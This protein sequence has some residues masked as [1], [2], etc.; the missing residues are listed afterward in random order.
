MWPT[1]LRPHGHATWTTTTTQT[2]R[3]SEKLAPHSN[4]SPGFP[5]HVSPPGRQEEFKTQS[6][7]RQRRQREE[8]KTKLS[9]EKSW[10]SY[11]RA[12]KKLGEQT[13]PSVNVDG[14]I[15]S[16][17]HLHQRFSHSAPRGTNLR[18]QSQEVQGHPW[19]KSE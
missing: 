6:R 11:L 2:H 17:Y 5:P 13:V 16:R 9:K 15:H 7:Q 3:R 18:L 4:T 19:G 1:E 8:K 10:R 12:V 14:D